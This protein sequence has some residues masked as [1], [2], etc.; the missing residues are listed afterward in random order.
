MREL[1]P[2]ANSGVAE[3]IE[4]GVRLAGRQNKDFYQIQ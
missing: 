2:F 3:V 1:M 4:Y